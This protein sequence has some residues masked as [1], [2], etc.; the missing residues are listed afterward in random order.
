MQFYLDSSD[1]DQIKHFH[2]LGIIEGVTTNPTLIAKSGRKIF[3]VVREIC[4]VVYTSVSVEVTSTE[5]GRMIE[6]GKKLASIGQQVVI[7]LPMTWAGIKACKVLSD[8]GI[9]VNM[10][11]CFT[12][13]QALLA[14]R[15]GAY[16][17]SP[18]I[19]RLDDIGH[20]GLK[21]LHNIKMIFENYDNIS[22]KILAASIRNTHHVIE[23]GKIGVEV[24]T[25]PPSVLTQLL[26]HP[27]TDRGLNQFL[28]DWADTGQSILDGDE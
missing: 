7:K 22:T 6:E 17:V 14:A 24:A 3:D 8:D 16:Y 26:N 18:F 2:D 21:I 23:A 13:T 20:D 27:M 1:I 4:T 15:V 11:L 9:K 19:G 28:K 12:P 25:V 10:T 5:S